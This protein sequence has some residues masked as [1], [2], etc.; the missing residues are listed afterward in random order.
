LDEPTNHLDMQ[1]IDALAEAIN[2]FNG[3]VV[4]VSHDFRLI[5]QVAKEIWLCDRAVTTFPGDIRSYKK[6][7]TAQVNKSESDFKGEMKKSQ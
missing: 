1:C 4:L 7:L 5:S 2:G 6:M 3:G